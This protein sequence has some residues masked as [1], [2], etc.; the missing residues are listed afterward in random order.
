MDMPTETEIVKPREAT[1]V[2]KFFDDWRSRICPLCSAP[3]YLQF[4]NPWI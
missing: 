1:P 3:L 2:D 4:R